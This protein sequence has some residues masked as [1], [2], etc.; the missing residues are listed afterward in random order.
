[1]QISKEDLNHSLQKAIEPTGETQATQTTTLER[2]FH[3]NRI[4]K[5]DLIKM[6]CEGAEF[7]ILYNAP[8]SIF[9][10][11]SHI[12]MEY[13]DWIEGESHKELKTYLEKL[14]YRVEKYPNNKMKELGFFWCSKLY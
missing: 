7:N 9:D 4:E 8:K 1:M 14:G 10:K 2:I 3:K 6:D 13:H 11:V 12:F 5:C